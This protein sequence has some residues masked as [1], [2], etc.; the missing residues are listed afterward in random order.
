[1]PARLVIRCLWA[2]GLLAG[3]GGAR[4]QQVPSDVPVLAAPQ[5]GHSAAYYGM[6]SVA[7]REASIRSVLSSV[8]LDRPR[9]EPNLA[10]EAGVFVVRMLLGGRGAPADIADPY[11]DLALKR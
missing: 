5:Q 2:A 6:D 7:E 3:A 1:M 9:L 4:A 11:P 10:A 8:D